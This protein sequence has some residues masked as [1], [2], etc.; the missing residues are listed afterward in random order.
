MLNETYDTNERFVQQS[1]LVVPPGADLSDGDTFRLGDGANVVT[2]EYDSGGG[3]GSGHVRIAFAATD[4]DYV[5]AARIRDAIN[6]D[7]VQSKLR[8]QAVLSDGR[9]TG[10]AS[11]S[12]LVVL[13][14]N[15][16]GDIIVQPSELLKITGVVPD[17]GTVADGNSL[18]AALLGSGLLPVGQ[19]NLIGGTDSA[20]FF[21]GGGSS[22]GIE[23]GIILSTGSIDAAEGP[24]LDDNASGLASGAGDASL[25]ASTTDTTS[26]EF[27]FN[28]PAAGTV[29]FDYVFAS[30]EYNELVGDMA[31]GPD[32]FSVFVN[33][34]NYALIPGTS[35]EVSRE[36]IN[37]SSNANLYNDNDPNDGG[38]W[39][40]ELGYDGFTDVL[41]AAV[42]LGAGIHSV[43]FVISDV[44]DQDGDS[45]VLIRG[46]SFD[47]S[48]VD[49]PQ[50]IPGVLHDG[51]GDQNVFRDQGQ[52][53]IHSNQILNSA[54]FGIVADAGDRDEQDSVDSY[55]NAYPARLGAPNMGPVRNLRDLNNRDTTGIQGGF[56]PGVVITNNT[57]AGEGLG[58]IHF[59]GDLSPIELTVR[60]SEAYDIILGNASDPANATAGDA[61][62]DGDW[63][64]ITVGRTT[65]EF[66]FEDENNAGDDNGRKCPL[67]GASNAGW[68][69]GRV[70]VYYERT[71]PGNAGYSELE[72]AQ[73]IKNAIDNSILVTNGTTLVAR[74][75][76]APSRSFGNDSGTAAP[77]SIA[78]PEGDWAVYVENA[79]EVSVYGVHNASQ[80]FENVRVTP[81]GHA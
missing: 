55:Y 51:F 20:G 26:L 6:S 10:Q 73:A 21:S 38:H 17:S 36:T 81:L 79:R 69:V 58:G 59:S 50:G 75:S 4:P 39:L 45:A 72:M 74:T 19:A 77:F 3:V 35:T 37:D 49:P 9:A 16:S 18:R 23:S 12:N 76:I 78:N 29:Y 22:I 63:F 48:V 57:I 14:G 56:A 33:G 46:G 11:R 61:V 52:T 65:V 80:V 24:N 2:F 43:K 47:T 60:R 28:L 1:T 42:P 30:E 32:A 64:S 5:I 67:G 68:E 40:R 62:C 27:Q 25:G 71:V 44:G 8:L 34:A 13:F 41:R 70:P 7:T 66:E 15:A 53:L 31:S 54:D